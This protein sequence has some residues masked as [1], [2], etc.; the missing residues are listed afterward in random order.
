MKKALTF[1]LTAAASAL[2]AGVILS[3]RRSGLSKRNPTILPILSPFIDDEV[4][5]KFL[6]ELERNR[7]KPVIVVIHTFGGG[8]TPC[9]QIARALLNRPAVCA[10]VPV[11]A[12]S[13]GTLIALSA[14]RVAL[15][16]FAC[17]S[18]VDPIV[19]DDELRARHYEDFDDV[20]NGLDAKECF[21]AMM[22][23]VDAILERRKIPQDR[24]TA[25]KALLSGEKYP[26]DWPL[27]RPMLAEAGIVTD[28]AE[29]F[30]SSAIE[31][32]VNDA[33]F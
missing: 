12:F 26:H 24:R 13:G 28:Q 15:G 25:A 27:S 6:F 1:G 10:V 32:G 19:G 21:D 22:A 16:E 14:E 31:R 20:L 7:G 4:A 33:F 17:L 18:A 9:A 5:D 3:N 8:V 2:V 29:P 11:K 30:W 23:L